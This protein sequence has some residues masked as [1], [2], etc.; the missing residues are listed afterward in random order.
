MQK[1][2]HATV[3]EIDNWNFQQML[4]LG[5]SETSHNFSSFRQL[6]FHNFQWGTKGKMLKNCRNYTLVFELFSF[7]TLLETMNKKVVEKSWNFVRFQKIWYPAFAENF[8]CLS[9]WEVWNPHP[10]SN[11]DLGWSWTSPFKVF[12]CMNSS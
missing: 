5:F 10:L 12:K 11:L 9:H 4:D 7:S 8:S 6:N 1:W 3:F 2:G